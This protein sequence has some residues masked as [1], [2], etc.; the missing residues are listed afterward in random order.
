MPNIEKISVALTPEI[1]AFVRD[2]VE[3]GEYA[4]SSEVI[5]EALQDWKQKRLLRLQNIDEVRHLWQEGIDSGAG[6]YTDIEAI[7]QEARR[8]LGQVSQKDA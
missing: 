2:V 7:K 8:R 1:A 6:Q 5:R 3:S 4:S